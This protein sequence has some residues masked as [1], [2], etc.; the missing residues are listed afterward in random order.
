MAIQ[1]GIQCVVQYYPL[2]RY[3]FYKKLGFGKAECPSTE[4][5]FDN[6]ISFPFSQSLTDDEI[7]L[8]VVATLETLDYLT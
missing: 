6:M 3:P 2:N 1:Y 4:V 5:F 7:D 8:I